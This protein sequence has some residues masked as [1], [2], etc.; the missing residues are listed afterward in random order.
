MSRTPTRVSSTTSGTT[1][2]ERD[3]ASQTMWPGNACTSGT[4]CVARVAAAVPHTPLPTAMRTHAGCPWNG[5]STSP[6]PRST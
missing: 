4:R 5:P 1:I 6:S 3:A 2:S